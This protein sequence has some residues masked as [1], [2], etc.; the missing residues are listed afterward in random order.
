MAR[1]KLRTE[2]VGLRLSAKTKYGLELLARKE[3]DTL[4]GLITRGVEALLEQG[5]IANSLDELWAD[6]PLERAQ[7]LEATMPDLMTDNERHAVTLLD[8][9]VKHEAAARALLK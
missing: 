3:N 8:F 9:D 6:D 5:G 2:A 7:K 4:T 1:E